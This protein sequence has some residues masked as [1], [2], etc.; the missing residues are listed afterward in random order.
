MYNKNAGVKLGLLIQCQLED[1]CCNK[2]IVG[3]V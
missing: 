3:E 1:C 2:C